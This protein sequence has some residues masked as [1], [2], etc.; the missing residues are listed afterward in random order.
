M[1]NLEPYSRKELMIQY[2]QCLE[3]YRMWDRHAWQVPSVNL[4]VG[5][6]VVGVAFGPLR[7][8]VIPSS[9]VLIFGIVL[10]SAMFI[11]VK[12]YRF[13]QR[14]AIEMMRFIEKVLS[15]Q[16]MPLITRELEPENWLDKRSAGEWL[17]N[18]QLM[19][20]ILLFILFIFNLIWFS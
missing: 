8:F 16:A 9:L 12:K 11:A 3:N 15:L 13:F 14:H 19:I 2:Q 7:G 5:S 4:L 1:E 18:T 17:A 10:S 20:S 6:A